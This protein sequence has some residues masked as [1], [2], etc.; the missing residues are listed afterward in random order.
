MACGRLSKLT[1]L[2]PA[3]F[4]TEKLPPSTSQFALLP[5][6]TRK[7]RSLGY[8]HAGEVYA[9]PGTLLH[10]FGLTKLSS[11]ALAGLVCKTTPLLLQR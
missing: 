2:K 1:Y 11:K 4:L 9:T 5:G 3:R 8:S 10:N 6:N 7:E